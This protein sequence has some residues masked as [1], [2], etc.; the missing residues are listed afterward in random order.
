MLTISTYLNLIVADSGNNRV[1]I[2]NSMPTVDGAS[3]D[4]VIGQLTMT[5]N[6]ANLGGRSSQSLNY[7]IDITVSSGKLFI[8]E[9][10]NSRVLIYNT[11]P[12][13]NH[14]AADVVVGQTN[15]TG[16]A[17]VCSASGMSYFPTKVAVSGGALYVLDLIRVLKFNTIPN[18]NGASADLVIGE[19]NLTTCTQG[20][21]ASRLGSS[22]GLAVSGTHMWVADYENSRVLQ[23]NT[24]PVADGASADLVLGQAGYNTWYLPSYFACGNT[25]LNGQAMWY[26][27]YVSVI[28]S[29]LFISSWVWGPNIMVYNSF[30]TSTCQ[31]AD[32]ILGEVNLQTR[33]TGFVSTSSDY[34]QPRG[35]ETD[36]SDGSVWVVDS[37][38]SRVL[39]F[40]SMP[41]SF[42][43][44]PSLVLGQPD[45]THGAINQGVTLNQHSLFNPSR[46]SV[47]SQYVAVSDDANMRVLVWNKS[48]LS[49]NAS[50][51]VVLGQPDFVTTR[52]WY[53]AGTDNK[54]LLTLSGVTLTD[55]GI[56]AIDGNGG[57]A[58]RI[59]IWN[60]IPTTNYAPADVVLGQVDFTTNGGANQGIGHPTA[61]TLNASPLSIKYSHGKLI[62]TDTYNHRILIWNGVPTTNNQPADLVI[63]QNTFL[64]GSANQ[65]LSAPTA[66]SLSTP[67]DVDF[68]GT[69]L[70][71]A[72]YD[73]HR[74]LIFDSFPTSNGAS[75]S[76]VW[77]QSDF[78]SAAV[79]SSPSATNLFNPTSV[80][81]NNGYLLVGDSYYRLLGRKLSTI[82]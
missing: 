4:V 5:T 21:G 35:L 66:S 72:D 38:A 9:Y 80:R 11:I 82:P 13:T 73:N 59:M 18:S 14:A 70:A 50:A 49:N 69:R 17:N 42:G 16:L 24:I 56:A 1:L 27:T 44:I 29:Q 32:S 81:F 79:P 63:G 75:A 52:Y 30:P 61:S 15:F 64:V 46:V 43:A 36:D 26:P 57:V 12:S 48:A 53:T 41:T 68:D 51:S 3:A 10:Y 7:P 67:I 76:R 31:A 22:Y 40:D 34:F 28:G 19:P 55:T 8:A 47:N 2:Y 45:F 33:S 74:V 62:V 78:T 77:G 20:S 65:G 6:T 37:A 71:V 60:T 25:S 54:T 23:W 39:R 58:P